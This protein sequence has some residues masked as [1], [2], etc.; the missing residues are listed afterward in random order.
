MRKVIPLLLLLRPDLYVPAWTELF[1][2]Y[3]YGGKPLYSG[4]NNT[5]P[6]H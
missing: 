6:A 5:Q 2:P 3:G 1:P 4:S